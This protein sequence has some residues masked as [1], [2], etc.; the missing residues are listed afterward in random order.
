MKKLNVFFFHNENVERVLYHN[1]SEHKT[2][3]WKHSDL[4]STQDKT[5]DCCGSSARDVS[6]CPSKPV[7]VPY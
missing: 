2:D 6:S 5:H 7:L 3:L 1:G 4:E